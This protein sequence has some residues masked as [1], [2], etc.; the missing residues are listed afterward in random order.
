MKS[1]VFLLTILSF[2]LFAVSVWG[3]EHNHTSSGADVKADCAINKGPCI[4]MIGSDNIQIEFN[5]NPKP[6]KSM[7]DLLFTVLLKGEKQPV[8]DA[9]VSIDLTMPG[10]FMGVN[11]PLLKHVK[12]GRYEGRGALPVCP[13]G[14]KLWKAEVEVIREGKAASV[15]FLFE[16]E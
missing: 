7:S 14:G 8:S 11:K 3:M 12:D 16:V 13:H 4:K 9:G 5:I 2:S 1:K 6:V 10:M 15:S